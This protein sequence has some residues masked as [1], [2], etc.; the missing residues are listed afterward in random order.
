MILFNV[1]DSHTCDS[2]GWCPNVHNHYWYK[3]AMQDYGC[4]SFINESLPGRSNDAMMKLVVKHCL[5]NPE[6][7]T[8]YIINITTIFR[9]DL[10]TKNSST[11]HNILTPSA[12]S[13]L[14]FET[15]EC[16]LY[17]HLIC[18]IEFLKANNKEFLI[19]NNGKNFSDSQLPMRDSYVT[20]FKQEPRILNWF[21]NS[22]IYFQEN[23]T[24]IK[25]VDF[26]KYGWNGHDGVEG[27]SRYYECLR[28]RLPNFTKYN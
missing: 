21:D 8:L 20:Y 10:A 22:R 23:V 13:E 12:I 18:L 27:H 9:I 2:G 16:T 11:L 25:P 24:K 17:A 19:V 4:T 14:D 28:T 3:I 5:D 26:D 15:I 6:L 7:P 1:G